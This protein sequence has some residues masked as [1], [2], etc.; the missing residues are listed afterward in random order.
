MVA[1]SALA[2]LCLAV[3][4]MGSPAHGQTTV[5]VATWNIETVGA[6][7]SV[8]YDAALEILARVDADVIAL[9][10]IASAADA[11]HLQDLAADAGYPHS[12]CTSGAPFGS[13]RNAI[14]SR[15]PFASPAIE[16]DA[17]SLSGDPAAKDI[18]RLIVEAVID[19][20]G[21]AVDLTVVAT[22]WK[23]GNGNDD[24]F[25]RVVEA[26]RVGQAIAD[27]DGAV[28]A[29]I[30]V[31]DVNEEADS[32]P[33]TPNPF[34]GLPSG[35]PGSFSLGS[36]LSSMLSAGDLANDP[37]EPLEASPGTAAQVVPALQVDGSDSTRPASGRRLDYILV[38]QVLADAGIDSEVFDSADEALGGGLAKS[39]SPLA[40][41]TSLDA[42]DHLVVFVDV[43]V[44][45]AAVEIPALG[46]FALALLV[47]VLV[48]GAT[49]LFAV[50]NRRRQNAT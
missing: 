38:S 29:F 31:G 35:L 4:A 17:A 46:A 7:G 41:S 36:D 32:T 8:E 9:H 16:H 28:D 20:P 30:V 5:R 6:P 25:R 44:P 11:V 10:E 48:G 21:N 12:A 50:R 3:L 19:V 1:R 39:G 34:T 47:A 40:A 15:H 2:V 42:A 43:T 22:H 33:R 49:T 14:L 45:A 24:E 18:T 27:L 37:F 13:D 26:Y 23:S